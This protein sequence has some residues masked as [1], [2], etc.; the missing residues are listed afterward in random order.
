MSATYSYEKSCIILSLNKINLMSTILNA[1]Q[2]YSLMYLLYLT[3]RTLKLL[4]ALFYIKKSFS[5]IRPTSYSCTYPKLVS[6]GRYKIDNRFDASFFKNNI[7]TDVITIYITASE[8]NNCN[9][10]FSNVF[11][12]WQIK[13]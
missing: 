2:V 10:L 4:K 11:Q 3:H 6:H 9:K 1:H 13:P 7:I 5:L 12:K 8:I